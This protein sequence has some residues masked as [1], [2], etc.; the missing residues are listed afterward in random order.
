MKIASALFVIILASVT[1][2]SILRARIVREFRRNLEDTSQKSTKD[3]GDNQVE[4]AKTL[5]DSSTFNRADTSDTSL[6]ASSATL[7][8]TNE[9]DKHTKIIA[10]KMESDNQ[11]LLGLD[12]FASDVEE[13]SETSEEYLKRVADEEKKNKDV[14]SVKEL[15]TA[16][17]VQSNKKDSLF[18]TERA[19]IDFDKDQDKLNHTTSVN[20][21]NKQ[22]DLAEAEKLSKLED[23]R[24][25]I[26]NDEGAE[27]LHTKGSEEVN[28][29][30]KED[31]KAKPISVNNATIDKDGIKVQPV[32][33]ESIINDDTRGI[34]PSI[35][36]SY[37]IVNDPEVKEQEGESP[38]LEGLR[39]SLKKEEK[40]NDQ[41]KVKKNFKSQQDMLDK[42]NL[43]NDAPQ[44]DVPVHKYPLIQEQM[45][46]KGDLGQKAKVSKQE[47]K[48]DDQEE[49]VEESQEKAKVTQQ[50]AQVDDAPE[51][52]ETIED[53]KVDEV[54]IQDED[55]Q[56]TDQVADETQKTAEDQREMVQSLRTVMTV[57]FVGIVA[58]GF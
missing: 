9:D 51:N 3:E 53:D 35:I 23:E 41:K 26:Q 57:I 34:Q 30:L 12:D 7:S 20:I 45:R 54:G 1:N 25:V 50:E 56:D 31:S 40:L 10:K 4:E 8:A 21:K 44:N 15:L 11:N 32:P 36:E 16:E 13:A 47:A 22:T 28:A 14:S 2:S 55:T 52:V 42:N 46:E 5:E 17:K 24:P 48:I 39:V 29:D 6:D 19:K 18:S 27:N 38:E 43:R 58:V 49:A 33:D 37:N